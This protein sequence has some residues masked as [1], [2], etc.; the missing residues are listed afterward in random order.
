MSG[1]KVKEATDA[2]CPLKCTLTP[3][4]FLNQKRMTEKGNTYF[5]KATE[6]VEVEE[7]RVKASFMNPQ[8]L[9]IYESKQ[10]RESM[11][12]AWKK[13][14]INVKMMNDLLKDSMLDLNRDMN[15]LFQ[16]SYNFE[17]RQEKVPQ[18]I[19]D[20]EDQ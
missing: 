20:R 1:K 5:L 10:G 19:R 3:D 18:W 8:Q 12:E 14:I 7:Q 15:D 17:D 11:K 2:S 4:E 16:Q 9:A 6:A 13:E